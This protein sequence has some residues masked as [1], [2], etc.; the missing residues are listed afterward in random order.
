MA[1]I[2]KLRKRGGLIVAMIGIAIVSFLLMDS[3]NSRT[4]IFNR[5][6]DVNVIGKI[7]GR[8]IDYTEFNRLYDQ[9]E[10]KT[11]FYSGIWLSDYQ[12]TDADMYNIRQQTWTDLVEDIV[13]E[14]EYEA[15]G[16][17]VTPLELQQYIT[18]PQPA[19]E[20]LTFYR[21]YLSGD[22]NAP[23]N[24]AAMSNFIQN[25]AAIGPGDK[26]YPLKQ[27]YLYLEKDIKR[28]LLRQKYINL[29]QKSVYT[30]EWQAKDDFIRKNSLVDFKYMA[31]RF[32]GLDKD[33][34]VPTD[35]QLKAY[36][37]E[38]RAMF[39]DEAIRNIEFVVWDILPTRQDT[40]ST[41]AWLE[42]KTGQWL[43]ARED[44]LFLARYSTDPYTGYYQFKDELK[45]IMADTF[46][47]VDTGSMVGPW[48]EDGYYKTAR[49][50]DRQVI[51]DSVK[52]QH[53]L[54]AW[55]KS[56][57]KDSAR[58][59][60][61]SVQTLLAQGTPFDTLARKI[62]DDRNNR[63]NGGDLGWL[64][65]SDN[66]LKSFKDACF[67][68]HKPGETFRVETQAG[69]HLV[70]ITE[71]AEKHP[72]VKVGILSVKITPGPETRDSVY[73]IASTFYTQH[74]TPELFEQGI[75]EEGLTK[76]YGD[77]LRQND[78][79]VPGITGNARPV[80]RWA[81][82]NGEGT[83][84]LFTE[85]ELKSDKYIV[86]LITKVRDKGLPEV[87]EVRDKIEEIVQQDLMQEAL[88]AQMKDA[89][90]GATSLEMVADKLGL[91][92]KVA[93]R[94][95]LTG[96]YIEELGYEPEVAAIAFNAPLNEI[97]GPVK[98]IGG[99]YLIETISVNRAEAPEN[100]PFI[101]NQLTQQNSGLFGPN[102]LNAITKSAD[103]EDLRYKF[104]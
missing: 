64:K 94:V 67:I 15:L 93:N 42:E 46:F 55:P 63:N 87:D 16:L 95:A 12:L 47:Q 82:N 29:L 85:N 71:S 92:V 91:E 10:E 17:Q 14:E 96:Q 49:V 3:L 78:F 99:V 28:N 39:E 32:E 72:A 1:V 104:Y 37:E 36:L 45:T 40:A 97:T 66:L 54:V 44:S 7:N 75:Q 98:G 68:H 4:G 25:L 51:P 101:Q 84:K 19:N 53:I 35:E 43:N 22:P 48:L 52:V 24:P 18:G 23:F 89:M 6:K 50:Y 27:F 33:Q 70:K 65:P 76:R 80:V 86:A 57:D 102:I 5:N 79:N 8:V 81:F 41:A 69:V 9:E 56:G 62:S 61:D 59:V 21:Q 73:S 74:N 60:M 34:F 83:M 30:P 88:M 26:A 90:Q 13:M 11:K 38:H 31:L 100:V 20:I 2:M 58:S 77:N 103:V